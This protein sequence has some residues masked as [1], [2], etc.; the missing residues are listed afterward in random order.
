MPLP[1]LGR[2]VLRFE[3]LRCRKSGEDIWEA[4]GISFQKKVMYGSKVPEMQPLD[5]ISKQQ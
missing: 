2:K 5:F 1:D 3:T 4:V